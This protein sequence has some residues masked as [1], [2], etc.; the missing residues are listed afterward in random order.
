METT[1]SYKL[2]C[3]EGPLD[4]LLQLISR[5]KLNIYDIPVAELL[6]QYLAQID[7]MREQNMDVQSEFLERIKRWCLP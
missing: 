4:L 7:A 1:L 6:E 5:N 2:D 3:F